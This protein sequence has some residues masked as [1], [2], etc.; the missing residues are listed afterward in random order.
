MMESVITFETP[1]N[2]YETSH[3]N[4]PEIIFVLAAAEPKFSHNEDLF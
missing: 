2:F 4:I 3:R 1:V